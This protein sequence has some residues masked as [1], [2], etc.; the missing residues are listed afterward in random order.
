MQMWIWR[1]SNYWTADTKLAA[2]KSPAQGQYRKYKN[3][4]QER[5]L[6]LATGEPIG[7]V[8]MRKYKF[9]SV[10]L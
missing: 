3:E 5:Y 7:L 10:I 2:L 1:I 8:V 4:R 9:K 6:P